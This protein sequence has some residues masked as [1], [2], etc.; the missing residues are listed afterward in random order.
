MPSLS[1]SAVSGNRQWLPGYSGYRSQSFRPALQISVA[2]SSVA[3]I[4]PPLISWKCVNDRFRKSYSEVRP[5]CWSSDRCDR[6]TSRCDWLEAAAVHSQKYSQCRDFR[7][8]L[9]H[10]VF[11]FCNGTG[12][13]DVVDRAAETV[14]PMR[15]HIP[16]RRVP[17]WEW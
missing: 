11:K 4:W 10:R 9:L 7:S 3:L 2:T 1:W 8:V 17:K 14:R 6:K 12:N 15:S 5:H 16:P 13:F